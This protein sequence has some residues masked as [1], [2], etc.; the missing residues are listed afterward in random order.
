MNTL[1]E[2]CYLAPFHI[3]GVEMVDEGGRGTAQEGVLATLY[4]LAGMLAYIPFDSSGFT[5]WAR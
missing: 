4:A 5:G 3:A 1:H 2:E